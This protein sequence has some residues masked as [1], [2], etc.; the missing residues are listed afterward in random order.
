[1]S[2]ALPFTVVHEVAHA[3]MEL[4]AAA[5]EDWLLETAAA[6]TVTVGCC[7]IPT[8]L[9]VAETVFACAMVELRVHVATPIPLAVCV[10]PAGTSV[11]FEPDT[12]IVTLAL[13]IGFPNPSLAVTEM[14]EAVFAP[15]VQDVWHAVMLEG[16]TVTVDCEAETTAG[17]TTIVAVC[18]MPTLL[19]MAEATF[20]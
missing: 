10:S 8:V 20:D 19:A 6:L 15:V 12:E 4:W 17:L 11:L 5:R 18:V 9:I 13:G 1:M 2:E 7:V 16:P 3:V 14:S